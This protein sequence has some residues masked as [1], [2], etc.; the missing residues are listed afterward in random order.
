MTYIVMHLIYQD[1]K[2]LAYFDSQVGNQL[3]SA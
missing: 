2:Y 1:T 3:I